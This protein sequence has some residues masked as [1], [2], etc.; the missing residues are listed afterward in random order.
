M[1]KPENQ[2]RIPEDQTY[3]HPFVQKSQNRQEVVQYI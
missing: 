1:H 2:T 3:L